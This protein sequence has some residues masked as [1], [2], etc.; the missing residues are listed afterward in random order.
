MIKKVNTKV[1]VSWKKL[2]RKDNDLKKLLDSYKKQN[3]FCVDVC[4]VLVIVCL[5]GI[6]INIYK[7][8]GYL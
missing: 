6:A 7:D 5:L 3:R 8:K 2:E 4:L 1:E